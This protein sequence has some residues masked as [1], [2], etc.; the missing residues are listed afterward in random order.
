MPYFNI[1]EQT[2]TYWVTTLAPILLL[3]LGITYLSYASNKANALY[4]VIEFLTKAAWNK[5]AIIFPFIKIN[6]FPWT[7]KKSNDKQDK[8]A[9]VISSKNKQLEQELT[10]ADFIHGLQAIQADNHR[11]EIFLKDYL[12][13]NYIDN[14]FK[15]NEVEGFI[16]NSIVKRI[17]FDCKQPIKL[18]NVNIEF[19]THNFYL[20]DKLDKLYIL[21]KSNTINNEYSK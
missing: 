2:Y 9:T 12:K 16:P 8:L 5:L 18:Y 6:K 3:F 14:S 17:S 21:E 11:I 1:D 19:N 10:S 13:D 20:N 15:I 7:K 4:K